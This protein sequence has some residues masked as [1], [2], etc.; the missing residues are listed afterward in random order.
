[1]PKAFIFDFSA[2]PLADTTA[3]KGLET[4]ARKLKKGGTRLFIA[5]AIPSVRRTLLTAG[6][7]EPDATYA[8]SVEDARALTKIQ[9]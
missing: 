6:L 1:M 9:I 4:F 8:A 2:V 7:R 3:A 5:G